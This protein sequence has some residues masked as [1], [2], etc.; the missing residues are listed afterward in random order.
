MRP[1]TLPAFMLGTLCA[2]VAL[3]QQGAEAPRPKNPAPTTAALHLSAA[4]VNAVAEELAST[5]KLTHQFFAEKTYNMEV[6]RLVGPQ[7][8]LRH[9]TKSDFMVI[10]DG[11]G[12]FMTGGELV[13]PQPGGGGDPGDMHADSTRGG[14]SR[15]LKPGDVMFVP[16]GVPHGFVET[17]DHVTFVMTRY[18]TK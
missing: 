15:V 7:P 12:T 4:Q 16:A 13:N 3:A 10:R 11:E 17:K 9:A 2:L 8:I 14:V 5:K 6:R 1:A 18:D